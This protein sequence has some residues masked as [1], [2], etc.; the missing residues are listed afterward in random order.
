MKE[1]MDKRNEIYNI[2]D[3]KKLLSEL[4]S[5]IKLEVIKLNTDCTNY[6]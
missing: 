2:K 6:A 5:R 4:P 3:L 1:I